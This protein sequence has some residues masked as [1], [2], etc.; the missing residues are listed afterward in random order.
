[1]SWKIQVLLNKGYTC[2]E[3]GLFA[4]ATTIFE[5]LIALSPQNSEYY[6]YLGE[7]YY[8]NTEYEKALQAFEKRNELVLQAD[9]LTPYIEGYK[10]CI[11][12]RQ[13]RYLQAEKLLQTAL[14]QNIRDPEIYYQAA[15]LCLLRGDT[16]QA[17]KI[18]EQIDKLDPSFC[19][20]KIKTLLNEIATAAQ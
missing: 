18:L 4:E 19:Y 3:K 11:Y 10:G 12:L 1:M 8:L 15:V 14:R 13:Q 17:H 2:I 16:S 7:A 5:E 6:A 20:K 9:P